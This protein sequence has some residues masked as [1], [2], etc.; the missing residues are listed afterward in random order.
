MTL[1]WAVYPSSSF[2]IKDNKGVF[3]GNISIDN[4]GGFSS[5]RFLNER[6]SVK[7]Y[8]KIKVKLKGDGKSYQFRIKTNTRD[9]HSYIVPFTT[10]G[11]WQEICFQLKDLYASFRGRKLE[12]PNFDAKYFEAITFLIGNKKEGHF[13]LMLDKIEIK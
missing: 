3:K 11:E 2:E 9:S 13:K 1:L 4:S 12:K 5:V 8:S 7:H 10:N 6:I